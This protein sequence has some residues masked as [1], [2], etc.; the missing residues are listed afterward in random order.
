MSKST[1]IGFVVSQSKRS[2]KY[3]V[4]IT[5]MFNIKKDRQ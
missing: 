5:K 1:Q 3:V 4:A 2:D